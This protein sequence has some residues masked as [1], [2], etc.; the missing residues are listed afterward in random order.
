MRSKQAMK[1]LL[2]NLIL[3]VIVFVS[4]IILPR[5]FLE[6]YGSTVNGMVTSVNQFLIYMGL[7]EAGVGTA[8]VVALYVP[9]AENNQS[10]VNAILSAT[11]RFYYRSGMLFVALVSSLVAFYPYMI[12]RQLPNSMVRMMIIVLASSTLVDYLLLGKY[13]VILTAMQ[14]GYVVA[15]AQIIGTIV[16]M[17]LS[18]ILIEMHANVVLVKAVATG[19]YILRFFVVRW[20]VR[21][22]IP[23]LDFNVEPDYTAL[24]QRGAALIHQIVGMIVNNTDVVVLTIMLGSASLIEVSVYSIYNMIVSAL[25]TFLNVFSNGLT[26]GFGEVIS[27]KEDEVLKESYSNFEYMYFIV[28]YIVCTCVAVLLLPFV[29][30][31]TMNVTDADYVRPL[32]SFLFVAI[33]FLQNVRIPGMTMICAAGHYK[34]TQPQAIREAVINLTISLLLVSKFKMIGVLLGTVCSYGYRS[35]EIILYNRKYLVKGTGK[36]TLYRLLRNLFLMII[37][38]CIGYWKVAPR[39]HSFAQWFIGAVVI[40]CF[41]GITI[42]FVNFICE[43]D[44]FKMLLSRVKSVFKR[45]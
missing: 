14:R 38:S 31:Y 18:I 15:I 22:K 32:A 6:E 10:Q 1:N 35:T 13:K 24:S 16:N 36:T 9:L 42:L 23:A 41:S 2:W 44:Q 43:P 39:I 20:Y 8:S 12:S 19:A 25:Y 26:A 40:G 5:F 45:K 28:F 34:E 27:K 4:G 21:K 17:T 11:K 3:Q 29:K 37:F 33:I 7:A 30:L